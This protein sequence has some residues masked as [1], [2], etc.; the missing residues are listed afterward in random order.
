MEIITGALKNN[1]LLSLYYCRYNNK[2]ELVRGGR[3]WV[4]A[5]YAVVSQGGRY[6]LLG[7]GRDENFVRIFRLDKI[8][9]ASVTGEALTPGEIS[10]RDNYD[11][12]GYVKK[13][14]F[15][16]IGENIETIV[17]KCGEKQGI[18]GAIIESFP[19]AV[20]TGGDKGGFT[21]RIRSEPSGFVYWALQ[22]CAACEVV[23]PQ[24]LRDEVKGMLADAY[25][26]YGGAAT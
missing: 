19:D 12:A 25:N 8:A 14:A 3:E 4:T 10:A 21:A 17:I 5:P 23:S 6:Y 13:S 2:K 9:G 7:K 1:R 24:Y 26:R 22:Y 11:T 15:L 16:Y 20:I 18:R